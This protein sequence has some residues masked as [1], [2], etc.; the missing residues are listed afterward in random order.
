MRT[1]RTKQDIFAT[2]DKQLMKFA[3]Y[4]TTIPD[5]AP[6][7]YQ[8]MLFDLG[9]DRLAPFFYQD[10]WVEKREA[11]LEHLQINDY[12]FVQFFTAI[13]RDGKTAAMIFMLIVLLTIAPYRYG[14]P[15]CFGYVAQNLTLTKDGMIFAS[16]LLRKILEMHPLS[17]QEK[18]EYLT[19]E[20]RILHKNGNMKRFRALASGEVSQHTLLCPVVVPS[21]QN[22]RT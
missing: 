19:T 14:K 2:G 21:R 1:K 8:Y 13:R 20:I 6:Y 16:A 10:I 22:N 18:V 5:H 4:I 7:D 15:L 12:V 11:V 3:T 17:P 9:Y